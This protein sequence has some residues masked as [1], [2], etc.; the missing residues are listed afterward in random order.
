MTALI[1]ELEFDA[2][3]VER[4]FV[5][6]ELIL[7]YGAFPDIPIRYQKRQYDG[8][9]AMHLSEPAWDRTMPDDE[10]ARQVKGLREARKLP[11]CEPFLTLIAQLRS[12]GE[13]EV[14]RRMAARRRSDDEWK[15]A[16]LVREVEQVCGPGR[17]AGRKFL[18]HCCLHPNDRDASLQVDP[19]TRLWHCFGCDRKGGVYQWRE[20]IRNLPKLP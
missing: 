16:D 14:K 10:L 1:P 9:S 2:T 7:D 18:F 20:A 12:F 15:R 4:I 13:Q 6:N 11:L 5:Q 3:N 8:V 19:D 17:K